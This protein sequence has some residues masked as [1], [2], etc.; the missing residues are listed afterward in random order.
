MDRIDMLKE[1]YEIEKLDRDMKTSKRRIY[2]NLEMARLSVYLFGALTFIF[3]IGVI[4]SVI[5]LDVMSL[6]VS[7]ALVIVSMGWMII[8]SMSWSND[9]IVYHILYTGKKGGVNA[10]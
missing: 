10:K 6:Y 8:S 3:I 4:A 1:R 9:N 2:R 7:L 5:S